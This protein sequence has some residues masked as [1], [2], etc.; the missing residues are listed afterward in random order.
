M[1]DVFKISRDIPRAKSLFEISKERLDIIKVL[2]KDKPYKILEEYYEIIPELFTSVMYLDGFKTLSHV[3]V[4]EYFFANYKLLSSSHFEIIDTMRKYRN[5]IIYYGKK[6]SADY[7]TN[8][9]DDIR[10]IIKLLQN[11]VEAKIRPA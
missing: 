2:P 1:E 5:S 10:K 6:I 8:N 7:L 9:E 3:S 4:I 11:F